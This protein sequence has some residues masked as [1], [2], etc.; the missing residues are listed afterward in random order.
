MTNTEQL[1]FRLTSHIVPGRFTRE[2]TLADLKFDDID[3]RGLV[4]SVEAATN[5]DFSEEVDQ[6]LLQAKTLGEI[7]DIVTAQ[8]E[9]AHGDSGTG[10]LS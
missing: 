8:Q 4:M 6:Q 1:I 2:T 5:L 10:D 9:A 3:L 7:I